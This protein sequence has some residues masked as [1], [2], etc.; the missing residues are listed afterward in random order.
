MILGNINDAPILEFDEDS[1]KES[2]AHFFSQGKKN[3]GAFD[4]VVEMGIDRCIIFLPRSFNEC[5]DIFSKCEKIYEFKSASTISP[6]YLYDNKC[7]IALCPLG[8]PAACNL[9]EELSYVGVTKYIAC[10]SCGCIVDGIDIQ[11]SFFIPTSAIRDEGLSYH[12]IPAARYI[13]TNKN[14]TKVLEEALQKH[15]QQY[16]LGRTWTIDA[17]YR[18]TPNRTARRIKEGAIGVE[19]ECASLAAVT[20]YNALTFGSL[21][22]FTDLVSTKGWNWRL[23]DKV[24]LRTRLV[25]IVVD[26]IMN[27]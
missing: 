13:E 6:V 27:L 8:G 10:G 24:E 2:K 14:V 17:L 25:N 19:M 9:V 3:F 22:Y 21:F 5:K 1:A 18:E 4:K 15:H 16:V 12:Y 20:E 7:L 23:Y 26:A 11:N